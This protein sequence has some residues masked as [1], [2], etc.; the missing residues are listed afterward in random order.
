MGL[1]CLDSLHTYSRDFAYRE[2][3]CIRMASIGNGD[4][5]ANAFAEYAM[6]HLLRMLLEELP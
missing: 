3:R 6:P 2:Q 1:Y 4:L 5:T